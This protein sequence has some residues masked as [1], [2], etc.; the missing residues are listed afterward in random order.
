MCRRKMRMSGLSKVEMSGF[1]GVRR[2]HGNGAHC[3]EST[4]TGRLRVL[5]EAKHRQ[6]TQVE[7][8]RR[9]QI[10]DRQV[11]R[12]LLRLWEQGDRALLHGLRG[13]PSNPRLAP[14]FEQKILARV[15]QRYATSGPLWLP[16]T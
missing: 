8:A 14:L 12:L 3:L 7:A 4:R 11:R 15:R 16:R 2:S 9:L 5:H 6:I 13:R 10:S 1:M